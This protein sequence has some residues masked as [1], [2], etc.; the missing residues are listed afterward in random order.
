MAGVWKFLQWKLALG[1]TASDL[2]YFVLRNWVSA[3]LLSGTLFKN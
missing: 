2:F 1:D 3:I